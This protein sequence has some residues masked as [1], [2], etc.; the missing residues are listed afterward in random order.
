[1]NESTHWKLMNIMARLFG[2]MAFVGGLAFLAT[3]ALYWHD[4]QQAARVPTA[5]GSAV[6]DSIGVAI[7]CLVVGTL[8]VLVDPY[9]PDLGTGKSALRRQERSWWTGSPR[10]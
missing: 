5:S 6:G 10:V 4:P 3:A 7:F 1:M 9:R 8:F 2:V